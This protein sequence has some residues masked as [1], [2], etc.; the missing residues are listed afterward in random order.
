M[1]VASWY[2]CNIVNMS[3]DPLSVTNMI[4]FENMEGRARREMT[5][6]MIVPPIPYP[7]FCPRTVNLRLTT[8]ERFKLHAKANR[9]LPYLFALSSCYA[10]TSRIVDTYVVADPTRNKKGMFPK[11]SVKRYC[12]KQLRNRNIMVFNVE[13]M[14]PLANVKQEDVDE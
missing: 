6:R 11:T 9:R 5:G 13:W 14:K 2:D 7:Q 10:D 12:V 4:L 1:H 3:F 8:P